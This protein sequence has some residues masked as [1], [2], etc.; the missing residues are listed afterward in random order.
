[1]KDFRSI[2]P[3]QLGTDASPPASPGRPRV[4]SLLETRRTKEFIAK[5]FL[6]VPKVAGTVTDGVPVKM[7][8]TPEF[9]KSVL[10][11]GH[12]QL[13]ILRQIFNL[14]VWERNTVRKVALGRSLGC[15]I[16]G[17]VVVLAVAVP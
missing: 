10:V 17:N 8:L 3:T 14:L 16:Q 6:M 9:S 1:M 15:P 13:K 12:V 7:K 11:I 2:S 5:D 4:S